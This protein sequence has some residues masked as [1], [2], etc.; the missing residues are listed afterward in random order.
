MSYQNYKLISHK[1]QIRFFEFIN[2]DKSIQFFS[3]TI[4]SRSNEVPVV[5]N[6]RTLRII[7][8]II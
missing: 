7:N 4:D 1:K 8:K 5:I 2:Y 6:Y 3:Y